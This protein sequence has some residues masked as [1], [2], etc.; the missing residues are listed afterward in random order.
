M[1]Q[2]DARAAMNRRTLTFLFVFALLAFAAIAVPIGLRFRRIEAYAHEQRIG[3]ELM[4][5][6]ADRRPPA[7][8]KKSWDEA[9]D[10]VVAAYHNVCFSESHVPFNELV[11]FNHDA[12]VKL[13]GEV[14][15][16]SIEW[17]WTRL[18]ETGPHGRKYV[19]RFK[20]EDMTVVDS[21]SSED[22]E[23]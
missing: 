6:L 19:D 4:V 20:S 14:D 17:I 1:T 16:H 18:A 9:T 15:I 7:V 23:R 13:G 11:R 22:G 2:L 12:K 10:R 8:P 3:T 5:S 21:S